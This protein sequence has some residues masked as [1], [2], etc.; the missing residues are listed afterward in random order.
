MAPP[1]NTP[2]IKPSAVHATYTSSESPAPQQQSFSHPLSSSVSHATAD[3][4]DGIAAR[5]SYIVELRSSII[6]LQDEVNTFLTGKMEEDKLA[7]GRENDKKE[8][9]N[10]GEEIVEDEAS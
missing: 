1:P 3:S 10:Y 8:E 4:S 7:V 5:E 6:T 9:E 2:S